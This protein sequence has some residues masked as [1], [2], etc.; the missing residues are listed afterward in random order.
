MCPFSACDLRSLYPPGL[1]HLALTASRFSLPSSGLSPK[2]FGFISPRSALGIFLQSF[3]LQEIG[4]FFRSTCPLT[5]GCFALVTRSSYC[6]GFSIRICSSV[7]GFCTLLELVH[8]DLV[9]SLLYGRCSPG[10]S[11]LFRGL[12][13][14]VLRSPYKDLCRCSTSTTSPALLRFSRRNLAWLLTSRS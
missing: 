13:F 5:V 9:V 7:S 8:I 12:L 6:S 1:P 2:P 10:F 4:L 3:L 14:F 11:F